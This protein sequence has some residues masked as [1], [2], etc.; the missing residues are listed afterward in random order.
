MWQNLLLAI[1]SFIVVW[2]LSPKSKDE[3]Q[4]AE[5]FDSLSYPRA[6]EGS[7]VPLLL[8]KR[9][10]R[11]GNAIW[12]GGYRIENIT[13]QTKFFF[14]LISEEIIGRNYFVTVAIA[15]C[16]GPGIRLNRVWID[17]DEVWSGDLEGGEKFKINEPE[18]FGGEEGSGG[19]VS[20]ISFTSGKNNEEPNPEIQKHFPETPAYVGISTVVLEDALLGRVPHLH[21][22]YFEASRY[23]DGMGLGI[24]AKIGDDVNPVEVLFQI[25]TSKWGG[26][27]FDTNRLDFDSFKKCADVLYQEKNGMSLLISSP[28]DGKRVLKEILRQIEGIIYQNPY[29]GKLVLRLIRKD[30]DLLE[31]PKL[32]ED[33]VVSLRHYSQ[34][35]WD[36]TMN[37]VRVSFSNRENNYEKSVAIVQDMAN[38]GM[39]DRV[40]ST[41]ISFPYCTDAALAS[42]LAAR[43]LSQLSVPLSQVTLEVNRAAVV[44][45]LPGDVILWSWPDYNVESMILRVQKF[46]YGDLE[47]GVVQ[48]VCLQDR[49]AV[50]ATV[51]APPVRSFH[52]PIK[53]EATYPQ[54]E[55][56]YEL[57][58]F[59][60]I[61]ANQD[62]N[63]LEKSNIT[64]IAAM[65]RNVDVNQLGFNVETTQ[66]GDIPI[67]LRNCS[68][69]KSAVLSEDIGYTKGFD[70][71]DIEISVSGASGGGA[72]L[73]STAT[74]Q[75]RRQGKHLILIDDE[76]LSFESATKSADSDVWTLKKVQRALLDTKFTYHAKDSVVWLINFNAYLPRD[77]AGETKTETK[78]TTFTEFDTFEYPSLIELLPQRRFEKP[79]PPQN[80][81]IDKKRTDV[82]ISALKPATITWRSRSR[83]DTE[84]RFLQDPDQN[85]ESGTT[86]TMKVYT[87]TGVEV[88]SLRQENIKTTQTVFTLPINFS[89]KTGRI[90]I[91]SVRD[92]LESYVPD[93]V[94]F[95]F[96]S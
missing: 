76:L 37:Q 79:L 33:N 58:Y 81:Q 6:S 63:L 93:I 41:N 24:L 8:G 20:N 75:E 86:W 32:N 29:T 9:R 16:L 74:I 51:Y 44:N 62:R 71:S 25:L 55:V 42:K 87:E 80:T 73:N 28:N 90:E 69:S 46:N 72:W 52:V 68:Y 11:S 56:V 19:F 23:T 12:M 82:S 27:N 34:S 43:E 38:I 64:W 92:N 15:L 53:N 77:F 48:L 66:I 59:L 45:L 2:L 26:L 83:T 50:A 65:V 36:D 39:L 1:G 89:T 84:I 30:Y 21:A 78:I 3:D 14:W 22:M 67:I 85:V 60:A 70:G 61:Q 7:P 10:I 94:Y 49:F 5:S 4:R 54:G 40:K 35:S 18:L 57:P 13:E 47:D 95:N 96:Q 31:L 91:S 88:R 17:K